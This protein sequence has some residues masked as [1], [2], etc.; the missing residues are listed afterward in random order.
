M[1]RS[2]RKRINMRVPE[3]LVDFIKKSSESEGITMTEDYVRYLENKKAS[4]NEGVP[5]DDGI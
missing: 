2:R 5:D 1:K 3:D 4:S